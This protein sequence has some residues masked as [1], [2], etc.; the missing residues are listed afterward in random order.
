MIRNWKQNDTVSC[1]VA[2]AYLL[3]RLERFFPTVLTA[4]LLMFVV[5]IITCEGISDVAKRI[6]ELLLQI[7]FVSQLVPFMSL[8]AGGIFWFL[9]ASVIAG[10][11][12]IFVCQSCGKKIVLILPLIVSILYN[13][14]YSEVNNLNVWWFMFFAGTVRASLVRAVA[15]IFTGVL[16]KEIAVIIKQMQLKTWIKPVFRI[17]SIFMVLSTVYI[18]MY[19]PHSKY[20][21]YMIIAFASIIIIADVFWS[22]KNN[23]ITDFLDKMCMPMYIFQVFCILILSKFMTPNWLSAIMLVAMDFIVGLIWLVVC[24]KLSRIKEMIII[25]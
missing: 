6:I 5:Q 11:L 22:E 24:P 21:F 23:Y 8:G 7:S 20:D 25:N 12:V 4:G 14:I 1:N 15:G 17:I 13:Y 16:S 3:N 2:L 18:T 10:T 19:H 9:S